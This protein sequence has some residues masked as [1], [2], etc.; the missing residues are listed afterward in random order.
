MDAFKDKNCKAYCESITSLA[1]TSLLLKLA[2]LVGLLTY[3]MLTYYILYEPGFHKN[4]TE[5]RNKCIKWVSFIDMMFCWSWS[6]CH[7]K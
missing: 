1:V 2:Q 5:A 7:K 4:M 3:Y 6:M